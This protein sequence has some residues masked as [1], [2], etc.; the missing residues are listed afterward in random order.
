MKKLL[1]IALLVT[2]SLF[3]QTP[4]PAF[5][6]GDDLTWDFAQYI[7][8]ESGQ[9]LLISPQNCWHALSLVYLGAEGSTR[10]ELEKIVNP[11]DFHKSVF[12]E[13]LGVEK[14]YLS[15]YCSSA[16]A[17]FVSPKVPIRPE[18]QKMVEIAG[19]EKVETVN[20]LNVDESIK[21]INDWV[22]SATKGKIE[23]L[24]TDSDINDETVAMLVSAL[25][26][27]AAWQFPFNRK[28]TR[29]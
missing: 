5:F 26:F 12:T 29:E 9:N 7:H 16:A 27:K 13:L 24:V 20:F 28:Q 4:V 1:T 15:P 17:L 25:H 3:A 8:P 6:A 21:T 14:N 11:Y 10:D 23:K 22:G 18:Y 2:Q 19:L